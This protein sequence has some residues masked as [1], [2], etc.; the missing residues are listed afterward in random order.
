MLNY[1]LNG[2]TEYVQQI[3]GV[4]AEQVYGVCVFIR[5]LL[6]LTPQCSTGITDCAAQLSASG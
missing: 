4:S 5:C 3:I 1:S 6:K 2:H